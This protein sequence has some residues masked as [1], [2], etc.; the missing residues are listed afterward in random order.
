MTLLVLSADELRAAATVS[1]SIPPGMLDGGWADEDLAVANVVA[2]RGLLARGLA[3]VRQSGDD[4][5]VGL[6][7]AVSAALR[8]LLGSDVLIEVIR[9]TASDAQR[10]L[11]GQAGDATVAAEEREPDVWRL[12][13]VDAPATQVAAGIVTELAAEL[14]ID[15]V[16]MG[17]VATVPTSA[18]LTA[19]RRATTSEPAAVI[20]E[21]T[22]AGLSD[23][24]AATVAA[25]LAKVGAFVTVRRVSR[26]DGQRTVDAL[27]WLEAGTSGT[28][29]AVPMHT[30]G[31]DDDPA[32]DLDHRHFEDLPY[33]D[34]LDPITEL[35]AV[36]PADIRTEL[37]EL[38]GTELDEFAGAQGGQ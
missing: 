23:V 19:E 33:W 10:W 15:Q 8:P 31:P 2:L 18:L 28:W 34:E 25:V 30:A 38:L 4:V 5:E 24:D 36:D 14:P 12:R 13:P 6:T 20:I 17:T 7:A 21:L 16:S 32:R 3:T 29:L 27:T 26:G 1:G 37:A 35:R 11:V 22:N 9:D